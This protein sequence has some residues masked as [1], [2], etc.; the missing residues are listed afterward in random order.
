MKT[1][2]PKP[3]GK[4]AQAPVAKPDIAARPASSR[5]QQREDTRRVVLDAA[6]ALFS[7]RGFDGTGLPAIAAECGVTVP[8]MLYHFKSKDLLWR[9]A[10]TEVYRRVDSHIE[11]FR[12]AIDAAQGREFY[13]QCSRAQ[14]TALAAHPEYM[15][16]LFQEGTQE[17]DRLTWMVENHQG[18]MSTT[19][20][21]IIG[22]A[23]DEGLLPKMDLAHAKFIISG[24]FCFPIVLAAEM[25]LVSGQD[26]L[27]PE[28]IER[29]IEH[30]LNLLL[31]AEPVAAAKAQPKP[32]PKPKRASPKR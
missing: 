27:A 2:S 9:E 6:I 29:H 19:L 5:E 17:S 3:S 1:L 22:R 12:A 25:K 32:K 20:M 13:R 7:R 31:P 8:L 24:A 18:R 14:I 21:A 16:I 10:V 23:Q 26:A 28:F 15:R 4:S 30:C 11:G